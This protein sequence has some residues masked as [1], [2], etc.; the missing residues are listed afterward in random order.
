MGGSF[1][2]QQAARD[3]LQAHIRDAVAELDLQGHPRAAAT[4]EALGALGDAQAVGR[5]LR[6][7]RGTSP[8]QRPVVQPAGA[9]LIERRRDYNLPHAAVLLALSASA[10]MFI[11]IIAVYLWPA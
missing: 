6:P 11:A 3:E 9:V 4:A 7:S 2:E 1:A 8:L 10:A 5:A